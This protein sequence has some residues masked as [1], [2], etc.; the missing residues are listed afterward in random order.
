MLLYLIPGK[1]FF[2]HKKPKPC[3]FPRAGILSPSTKAISTYTGLYKVVPISKTEENT[4]RGNSD[5][6]LFV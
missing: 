1:P 5:F 3:S 6:Y 4:L 2:Q